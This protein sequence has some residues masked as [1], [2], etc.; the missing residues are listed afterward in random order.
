MRTLQRDGRRR[1]EERVR[2]SVAVILVGLGRHGGRG[3]R[4]AN[5]SLRFLGRSGDLEQV[6]HP[7]V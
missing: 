6:E 2:A 4:T 5:D 1:E 3:L 7:G